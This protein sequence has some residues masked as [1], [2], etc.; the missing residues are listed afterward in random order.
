MENLS[1]L[2]VPGVQKV[3]QIPAALLR[4]LRHTPG[5]MSPM[6]TGP[7]LASIA[8]R[9]CENYISKKY[10]LA[11]PSAKFILK[12]M[13]AQPALTELSLHHPAAYRGNPPSAA[14]F[15]LYQRNSQHGYTLCELDLGR[16]VPTAAQSSQS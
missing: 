7:K 10:R 13:P 4:Y 1:D 15:F 16:Y 9:G 12:I 14:S 6:T 5:M 2:S 8:F 11:T 3:R